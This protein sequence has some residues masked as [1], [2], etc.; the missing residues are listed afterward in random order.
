V[1]LW[2]TD[3]IGCAGSGSRMYSERSTTIALHPA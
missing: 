1:S 3:T 2:T